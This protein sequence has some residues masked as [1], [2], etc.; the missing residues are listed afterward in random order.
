MTT[1]PSAVILSGLSGAGKST[2]LRSL[3]DAGFRIFDALPAR[4]LAES[5]QEILAEGPAAFVID[6]RTDDVEAADA[7][8]EHAARALGAPIR[9]VF[10]DASDATL[11]RRYAE[12]RRP[13]PLAAA[14]PDLTSALAAER[15]LLAAFASRADAVIATDELEPRALA[16]AILALA[17]GRPAAMRPALSITSFGFKHGIP[18]DAEWVVDVRSLPNPHYDP[19]LRAT[20]GRTPAVAAFALDNPRGERLL[21]AVRPLMAALLDAAAEDGR[22]TVTVAVGCTGGFHR[23][24]AVSEALA[25]DALSGNLAGTVR[26]HHRDIARR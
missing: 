15:S 17:D 25:A 24:V 10:L 11:L 5:G 14:H 13:H 19:A 4:V 9:R 7:A 16:T 2:A 21:A 3:E 26:V 8:I 22:R 12:S 20:D 1:R 6:I 18:A 23:S